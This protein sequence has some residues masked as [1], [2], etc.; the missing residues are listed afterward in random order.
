MKK[1]KYM[2]IFAVTLMLITNNILKADGLLRSADEN[3]PKDLLQNRMTQVWINI[4]GQIAE[5]V[6]YQEFVNEWDR[7]TDAV[8]SFPL[9]PDARATGL[10][11]W[12]DDVCY[13]AI[14]KV[15][16]Q[17]VNPGTG[18]GGIVAEINEYMGRNKITLRLKDIPAKGIQKVKLH[19][20]QMCDYYDGKSI[21]TYPLDTQ[22]FVKYPLDLLEIRVN[23]NTNCDVLSYDLSSHPGWDV[24]EQNE[25]H[26]NLVYKKSKIY[27]AK[28]VQFEYQV[29]SD[30]IWV[31]FYSCGNDTID[32]HFVLNVNP[33][34]SVAAD[35]VLN[36]RILFLLDKS[37]SMYGYKFDES[38]DAISACMDLL[39]ENDK[40]N[41]AVFDQSIGFYTTDFKEANSA[42]ITEAKKFLASQNTYYGS[43]LEYAL[44]QSML[45]FA[46]TDYNNTIML[47]TDGFSL[48]DPKEIESINN[49]NTGIIS[50]AIGDE[51][52]RA[53]LEMTSR[54]NYGFVKYIDETAPISREIQRVFRQI[55]KPIL[56]NPNIEFGRTGI[57]ETL[58][59]KLPSIYSGHFLSLVGRYEIPGKAPFSIAGYTVEGIRG[60]DFNLDFASEPNHYSFAATLWAKEK[61][62]DIE[63]HIAVYGETDSLKD[64][65]IE[66]S[67]NYG[68]RCKY[69]AYEADYITRA[70]SVKEIKKENN[71]PQSCIIGSYPNPF[72]SSTA[73]KIYI[74]PEMQYVKYKI[75]RIYNV[76]GQIVLEID[77][78]HLGSGVHIIRFNGKDLLGNDLPSGIYLCQLVVGGEV[79]YIRFTLLK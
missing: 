40:F 33:V 29:E 51:V 57:Y 62:D 56:M 76:L 53:R 14:L 52:D 16:A 31:D 69:T 17:V 65:D 23:L 59:R 30:S 18:E 5:T 11:Y 66:L 7:Q 8:Y 74:P 72:N 45:K 73:I 42:N 38:K 3:Y 75:L 27:I 37:T 43:N 32:G 61:I 28:D 36:K 70:T 9:P 34:T 44:T 47:F 12:R 20:L 50:I 39:N 35:K 67:L 13:K 58:P 25:R 60:Y 21:Y 78:S 1:I 6:V 41:I 46:D 71:V 79:S 77:I 22:Q 68:I 54:L 48:V 10:Y 26:V 2:L 15:K 49:N 24:L 64:L 55:N 19:Y 63:R 4:Y